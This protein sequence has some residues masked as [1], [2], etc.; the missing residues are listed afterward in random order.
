MSQSNSHGRDELS[1]SIPST[2]HVYKI[3]EANRYA[4][5]F[6]RSSLAAMGTDTL[7]GML[8]LEGLVST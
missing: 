8:Q 5:E 3:L 1:V 6:L 4:A 2:K 7:R